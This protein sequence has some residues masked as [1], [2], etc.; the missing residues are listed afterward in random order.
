MTHRVMPSSKLVSLW[1]QKLVGRMSGASVNCR[2]SVG[3]D[4][5]DFSAL[6]YINI[7]F[8]VVGSNLKV[9]S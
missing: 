2:G 5:F 4:E 6:E 3:L 1:G 7:L 8:S 9:K